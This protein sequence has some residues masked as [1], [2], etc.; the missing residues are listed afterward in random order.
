MGARQLAKMEP[1]WRR[2]PYLGAMVRG[3][4]RLDM[5]FHLAGEPSGK[6]A[7]GAQC[8]PGFE[9]NLSFTA[10]D[11]LECA[12]SIFDFQNSCRT[13]AEMS[14]PQ[15]FSRW[16][17]RNP[18]YLQ[19]HDFLRDFLRSERLALRTVLPL[20]NAAFC[21]SIPERALTE[22]AGRVWGNFVAPGNKE[23]TFLGQP[24]PC[25]W[26]ELFRRWLQELPYDIPFGTT[27]D[28][29]SPEEARFFHMDPEIWLGGT[30]GSRVQHPFLG[31]LAHEWLRRAKDVPGLEFYLD[32][33]GYVTNDDAHSF[34][35]AAEP[36][37]RVV[38]VF[39]EDG[40]DKVFAVGDGLVGPAFKD[41]ELSHLSASEFRGFILETMAVYGAFRRTFGAHMAEAAQT[42]HHVAC[43]HY[44]DNFCN[45]YPLIPASFQQCG[46]PG[47]MQEW[48][49]S[50]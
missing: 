17:K 30:L 21:T 46:F 12:A 5:P 13:T 35:F 25:R 36:Q 34:A 23:G 22:L 48:I 20:I 32:L 45:A 27:A 1:D 11:M 2:W 4:D 9:L 38:R 19:I 24:E 39:F 15:S 37:L 18:A 8:P 33:P 49:A 28:S 47:R 31:P 29:I 50:Q 14:D 42:C 7:F 6:L 40:F 44:D 16:R 10:K 3:F 41:P 43:P 26:P